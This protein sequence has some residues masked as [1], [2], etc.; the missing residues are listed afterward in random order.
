MDIAIMFRSQFKC[1]Y[2]SEFVSP[3]RIFSKNIRLISALKRV[4]CLGGYVM[5]YYVWIRFFLFITNFSK[6]NRVIS[7]LKC[8]CCHDG[9]V[10]AVFNVSTLQGQYCENRTLI[11]FKLIDLFA[12]ISQTW[13]FLLALLISA[14]KS[15]S[16][17]TVSVKTKH[18]KNPKQ[19]NFPEFHFETANW[20]T[21]FVFVVIKI[22]F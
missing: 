21:S 20:I 17:L 18:Y 3:Y 6:N 10:N 22:S 4:C 1:N 16:F 7:A 13:R 11:F 14:L 5:I 19:M 12:K 9:Y 2:R 8:V 15:I